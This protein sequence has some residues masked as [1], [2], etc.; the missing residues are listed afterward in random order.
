[1]PA[2]RVVGYLGPNGAGKSTADP[3]PARPGPRRRDGAS[4]VLGARPARA[5][6]LLRRRIGYLPGELRLDDRLT[7][8]ETFSSWSRLRGGGVDPAYVRELCERLDLDL[9]RRTRGLS[10]GNR[11]KV[12]LVGA[13]M[14]RPELLILDEPTG[15]VDPIVQAESEGHARRGPRRRPDGVPLVARPERGRS[16]SPTRSSI[17][18]D[19]RAVATATSTSS[20]TPQRQPFT[21][22]FAGDPPV[23]ELRAS[24]VDGLEVRGREVSGVVEGPPA[25]ARR[26]RHGTTSTT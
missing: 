15:G 12:G 5:G 20:A 4:R 22:W 18:R 25:A 19:G 26:A 14:A 1:M 6:P 21:A 3:D 11:R 8:E 9:H 16:R 2:G 13:F 24:G 7:V 10:T 17:I 23:D